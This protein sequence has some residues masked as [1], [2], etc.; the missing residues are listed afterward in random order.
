MRAD[1]VRAGN[2]QAKQDRN[3]CKLYVTS[4][5]GTAYGSL[6]KIY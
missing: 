6:S 2:V 3:S 1:Q 4:R 5:Q